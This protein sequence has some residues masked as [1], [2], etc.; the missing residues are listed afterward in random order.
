LFNITP[1]RDASGFHS[2]LIGLPFFLVTA[3]A[4]SIESF[5]FNRELKLTDFA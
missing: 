1:L 4:R 5:G 3:I 2:S